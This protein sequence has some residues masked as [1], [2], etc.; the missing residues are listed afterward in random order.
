MDSTHHRALHWH[1]LQYDLPTWEASP[2]ILLY[3][4]GI[5]GVAARRP[6]HQE[7]LGFPFEKHLVSSK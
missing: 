3:G 1:R 5:L 6:S 2:L 7:T 4:S